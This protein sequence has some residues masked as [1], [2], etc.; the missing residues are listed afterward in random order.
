MAANREDPGNLVHVCDA[1]NA[2]DSASKRRS[3]PT[4]P[5]AYVVLALFL[6]LDWQR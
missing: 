6:T 3:V 1:R 2:Q 4:E 5:L